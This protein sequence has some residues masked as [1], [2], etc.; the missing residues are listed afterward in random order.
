M[1]DQGKEEL[2]LASERMVIRQLDIIQRSSET[3]TDSGLLLSQGIR[4]IKVM[5]I[6][7]YMGN[8]F[9]VLCGGWVHSI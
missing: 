9:M 6:Q 8:L 5:V 4:R 2:D 7:N 3:R 1:K